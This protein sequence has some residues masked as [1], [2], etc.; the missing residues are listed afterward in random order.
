MHRYLASDWLSRSSDKAFEELT[1]AKVVKGLPEAVQPQPAG[2]WLCGGA[3]RAFIEGRDPDSDYDFF[4]ATSEAFVVAA[5]AMRHA[6]WSAKRETAHNVT[7]VGR[8]EGSSLDIIVQLI[9]TDF[10][11]NIEAVL[12]SFDFT[13]CQFGYDG[14]DIVMGPYS[15][16]DLSRKRIAVHRITY[17]ASSVRRLLKY[18]A[19]GFTVCQG[20]AT[21]L[22]RA[23]ASDPSVIRSDVQYVD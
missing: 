2:P 18:A 23:V 15:A 13:I 19:K 8:V 1:F 16:W 9:K 17:A 4:F 12:D 14:A 10:Y 20:A 6:G 22:L 21:T 5:D 11:P 7:F 3:V